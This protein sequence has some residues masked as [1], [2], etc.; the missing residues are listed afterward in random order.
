MPAPVG[1]VPSRENVSVWAGS[2]ASV[3]V[4]V[5]ASAV[6]SSTLRSPI[7]ASTG[8]TFASSPTVTVI[9]SKSSSLGTPSSVTRTVMS[10]SPGPCVVV[11][12]HVNTPP[13]VI[14]A[15]VGAPG[16]RL[17]VSVLAGSSAS[18]AVAVN[19]S[20]DSCCTPWSAIR[21]STGA[22]F[23]SPTV[24]VMVSVSLRFGVPLS[25]TR[26]VTS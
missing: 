21:P 22:T 5:N 11:G 19:V 3:A 7:S 15:P 1:G 2:L 14:A 10:K 23:T 9:V 17:K 20:R 26:T 18:V 13:E 24:M 25:V 12:V 8:A 4:A 6:N 16:S